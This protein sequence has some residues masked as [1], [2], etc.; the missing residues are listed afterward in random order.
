MYARASSLVSRTL[1]AF[2]SSLAPTQTI[3]LTLPDPAKG[4]VVWLRRREGWLQRF[5][6]DERR[7]RRYGLVGGAGVGSGRGGLLR[8]RSVFSPRQSDESGTNAT[9]LVPSSHTCFPSRAAA[10]NQTASC[11]GHGA[12]VR[13]VTTRALDDGDECWVCRCDKGWTGEGCE[14]QDRSSSVTRFLSFRARPRSPARPPRAQPVRPP[15]A[16][17]PR[18]RRARGPLRLAPRARRVRAAARDARRRRR[19]RRG[20]AQARLIAGVRVGGT[21]SRSGRSVRLPSLCKG[22]PVFFE[23]AL[24][25]SRLLHLDLLG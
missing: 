14:K 18:P 8:K 24:E 13:G 23:S 25:Q 12:P 2:V 19:R 6:E 9:L 10:L 1:G 7:E 17:H 15:R 5:L 20:A 16:H 3:A 22:S 21:L 11:L 4:G